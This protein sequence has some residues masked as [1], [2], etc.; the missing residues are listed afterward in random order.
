V[1]ASA[2]FAVFNVERILDRAD[3]G[4]AE[5]RDRALAEL[6]P[7]FDELSASVLRDEL[8]RRVSG[9]LELSDGRLTSLLASGGSAGRAPSANGS[10]GSRSGAGDRPGGPEAEP[11]GGG[12]SQPARAERLFL[13]LC[14]ALPGPGAAVLARIDADELLTSGL[15][16]RAARHLADHVNAPLA[17]LPSDDEELARA[18][19]GL[20]EL[21]GRV[22]DPREDRLEATRLALELDRLERAVIRARAAGAGTSALARE[23]E[24]VRD[25]RRAVVARLE[26]TL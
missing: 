24:A 22:P 25:E 7:V 4:S 12:P 14:L 10:A 13:A 18:V 19:S 20:V 1:Q 17:D 9:R 8:I 23:R 16:R 11:A 21:A 3:T 26:D 2:P 15:L 6:R 5:G